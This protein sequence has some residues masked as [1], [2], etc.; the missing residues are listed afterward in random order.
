MGKRLRII[1]NYEF[2]EDW[3]GGTY[4]IQNLVHALNTLCDVDKPILII[5]TS[6]NKDQAYQSL[7]QLTNYPYLQIYEDITLGYFKFTINRIFRK[8]FKTTLFNTKP[9][10]D[11]EFPAFIYN[12]NRN[13]KKQIF[14]IPDFQ[15]KYLP[16]FFSND[17]ITLR[18]NV[19]N[20]IREKA[21]FIVFSSAD[22]M[23]DFNK[24]Y[25]GSNAKQ[26]VFNFATYH[27]SKISSTYSDVCIKYNIPTEYFLCSNQFWIHKNHTIIF[28]A[29][30]VLKQKG[31]NIKV[32]CTGK[33]NDYRNPN[34]ITE[35]KK[36]VIDL[37][38][39]NN[40]MFLGFIDRQDQII[41]IRNCKAIIQPSYFEGWSTVIED[42]MAENAYILASDLKVNKEQLLNYPNYKLFNPNDE[43]A[44]V[45]LM[46]MKDFKQVSTDYNE[47]FL[48][49]GNR[50][51]EIAKE[52]K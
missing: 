40:I 31:F 49:F 13:V 32:I 29:I 24:F 48:C 41:L 3:M 50:F 23:N 5:N 10:Y 11:V 18:D 52:V 35:L 26:F 22:A 36:L 30:A 19:Y 6:K 1:I 2:N 47:R 37:D 34:Y 45:E 33:E 21:H 44:L 28:K 7:S 20:K 39:V 17:E 51:M 8:F 38:I 15:S 42:A 9:N 27:H 16:Q 14:W 25:N 46:K 12:N 43:S 4:Y